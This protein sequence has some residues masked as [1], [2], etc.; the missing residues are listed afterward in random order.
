MF[1]TI[2]REMYKEA[3]AIEKELARKEAEEAAKKKEE[4]RQKFIDGK[5]REVCAVK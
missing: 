3:V 2:C 4:E 5:A 1:C